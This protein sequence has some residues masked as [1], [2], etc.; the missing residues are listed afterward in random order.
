MNWPDLLSLSLWML[1]HA[2]L[3][4]LAV[5]FYRRHLY[6]EFPCFLAYVCYEIAEFFFLFALRS[7]SSVT[8]EQYR[9][10]YYA[11]LAFSVVLR[12][13]VIEEI[14]RDLFREAHVLKVTARRSLRA[15]QVVLLVAGVLLAVYAPGD[16]SVRFVAGVTAL[17]RGLAMVQS[18]LLL[19]LLFFCGF[20]GL[21]WR[22]PVFGITLGLGVISSVDLAIF[23]VRTEFSNG[24]WVPYLDLLRTGTYLV[25]VSL[26]IAYVLAPESKLEPSTVISDEEVNTW[27]KELQHLLRR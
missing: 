7:M 1:P 6:R 16:N 8:A 18:G 10:A 20:L 22:R 14:F 17:N 27:N 5:V 15:V 24:V 12:F 2:F 4:V 9:Y 19:F 11:T 13:G 25:C 26:W 3:G 23:A 21:S